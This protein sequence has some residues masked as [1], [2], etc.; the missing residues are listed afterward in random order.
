MASYAGFVHHTYT[1]FCVTSQRTV[2]RVTAVG[3]SDSK[4]WI[5]FQTCKYMIVFTMAI[6]DVTSS[7][8]GVETGWLA[9]FVLPYIW[10]WLQT[11]F[12]LVIRFI[13]N[14]QNVTS[15]NYS[16]IANSHTLYNTLQ[17]TL[18]ILSRCSVTAS[19]VVASSAFCVHAHTGRRMFPNK[20]NSR[21]VPLITHRHRS[22]RK[23]CFQQFYCGVMWLARTA[24][25]TH[26][27]A[28][29]YFLIF[30]VSFYNSNYF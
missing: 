9:L 27:H 12:R 14:L 21:F 22:H 6:R 2:Y 30:L 28:T 7:N 20:L 29:A 18:N 19:N 16:A 8:L 23:H 15:S 13:E 3:T 4:D 10:L 24:D 26:L 17:H 11:V 25:K 5:I 1:V